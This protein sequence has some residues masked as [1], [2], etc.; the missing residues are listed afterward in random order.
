MC[1]WYMKKV[2]TK[3]G[4]V[5]TFDGHNERNNIEIVKTMILS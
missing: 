1:H 4:Q 3:M 2:D 5:F